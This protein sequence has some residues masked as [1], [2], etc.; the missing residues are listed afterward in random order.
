M[1][2]VDRTYPDV[3]RDVLTNLTQGV[4]G[5]IH[6]VAY[7]PAAR[8][9][10]VP[11]VVL[12]R[13]PVRR[14]SLVEG[15]VA[16][17][18]S[19]AEPVPYVFTLNDYEL[20]ANSADPTDLSTIRFLPFGR[21]PAPNTE[22]RVNY[23]PRAADPTVLTDLNVGSVVRTLVE[24]MSKEL[25]VLYAQLNLAY[26]SAFVETATGP[27]LDRVVA[28]LGLRR[29]RAGRPIGVVQFSR[30]AGSLGNITIPAGTPVTD[31]EDTVR[32][33]TIDSYDMLAGESSA[34]VRVR[35]A[36]DRTPPVEAGVLRVIQRAIAGLDAVVNERPTTRAT[37]DE[38]DDELRGRARSALLASSKGTLGALR[39]GLLQLP[40]VRDVT[41]EEYP[42]GTPGE[43]RL[44]V[45]LHEPRPDGR[46]PDAVLARIEELRPAG[47][48]VLRE[49]AAI[50]ALQA[51][52]GLVLAGSQLAPAELEDVHRTARRTLA[53][54]VARAGVGQTL[55]NRP[56][57]AA[58]LQDPRIVDAVLTLGPK[59]PGAAP[60]AGADFAPESG[61]AVSLAAEDISFAADTF[62][63]PA[64]GDAPTVPVE[65]RAV[66]AAQLLPGVPLQAAQAQITARLTQFFGSLTP[67]QQV[68][69]PALLALLRDDA[70]YGLDPLRLR[71]TLTSPDQFA[72]VVQDGPPFQVLPGQRFTVLPAEVTS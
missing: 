10:Q 68:D 4:T 59:A 16:G 49:S 46:L 43:I 7:D 3:V 9:V 44:S 17:P 52:L 5:E 72:Q 1:S 19:D 13:R 18:T 33:E 15:K 64:G 26:D 71:V 58:I 61:A 51:Q 65:V 57:V 6:H 12:S 35:G 22:L 54:R 41:I 63:R 28:L 36:S 40:E 47:I 60:V 55:R 21:R 2:F 23:Y 34:Q 14:V 56:L 29:F 42:N 53:E 67:G 27:S 8:P 31:A 37:E 69:A 39:F 30:R 20:V 32:Y 50:V 62:D 48:R 25:A 70:R 11:D 38:L 24:A 45:S 66:V